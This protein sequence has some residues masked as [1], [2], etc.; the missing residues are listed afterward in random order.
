MGFRM[1]EKFRKKIDDIDDKIIDLLLERIDVVKQVGEWKEKNIAKNQI[2]I[3]PDREAEI[4]KD[5]I[6]KA[7]GKYP[8]NTIKNIW[9][10]IISAS[11][12][13]EQELSIC[14]FVPS[15]DET[16]YWLAREYFGNVCDIEKITDAHEI[17]ANV[18]SGKQTIGVLSIDKEQKWWLD[19]PSDIKIF[20]KI[21]NSFC[22]AKIN[23]ENDK[24]E[25]LLFVSDT[26]NGEI[27]DT[28]NGNIKKHLILSVEKNSKRDAIVGKYS[29][30]Q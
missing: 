20:A 5:M 22:I 19:M 21:E 10:N 28:E 6:S 2:F 13:S 18:A 8:D 4:V 23:L 24:G 25:N 16:N 30:F 3:K 17:V 9:R 26:P 15:D 14:A 12:N 11:V 1:L 29:K 7:K 27:L